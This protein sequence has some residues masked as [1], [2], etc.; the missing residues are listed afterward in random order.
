MP[1][2]LISDSMDSIVQKILLSEKIEVDVK[3]DLSK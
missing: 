3:I 1:K 2:V